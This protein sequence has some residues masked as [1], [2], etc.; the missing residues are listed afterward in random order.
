M[1]LSGAFFEI[2]TLDEKDLPI[3]L[4]NCL[5]RMRKEQG[6]TMVVLG[7]ASQCSQS[8]LSKVES[9]SVMPSIPMLQRLA[10][11]LGVKPS[12]LLGEDVQTMGDQA[13]ER[14]TVMEQ[15]P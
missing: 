8:F 10:R 6:M 7:R 11:A 9:G 4:G 1:S 2:D 13:D 12:S 5:R 15:H 14:R 3:T